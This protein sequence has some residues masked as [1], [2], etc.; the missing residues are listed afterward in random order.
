[1][2]QRE[3]AERMKVSERWVR[4]LLKR[5]KKQGDGV[6]VHGLRGRASNRKR[7]RETRR[8]AL[9]ILKR[10]EWHDFGPTFA[11]EQLS[12]RHH[13]QVSDET[14]RHWMREAGLWKSRSRGLEEVHAWRPRRSGFGEL[15]QWDTRD[16]DWL[17]GRGPGRAIWC[18]GSMTPPVGAGA[19]LWKATRR[20]TTGRAVGVPGEERPQGGR[21]HRP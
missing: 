14:L 6:V 7:S 2:T 13:I 4:T 18:A 9:A 19:G 3:A 20:R 21:L 11:A 15:V 17:E 1:M 12:K 10:P 8:Q 5:M 16:H